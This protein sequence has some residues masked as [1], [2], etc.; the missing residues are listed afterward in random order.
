[1]S[2]AGLHEVV[3]VGLEAEHN[4]KASSHHNLLECGTTFLNGEEEKKEEI[5]N[6]KIGKTNIKT[7]KKMVSRGKS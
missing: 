1:M 2:S 5:M 7:P 6:T 3:E 4:N